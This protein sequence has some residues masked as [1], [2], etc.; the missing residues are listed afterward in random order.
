MI[1]SVIL[2]TTL[3]LAMYMEGT[4][5]KQSPSR[6][7]LETFKLYIY[8]EGLNRSFLRASSHIYKEG[9]IIK[10]ASVAASPKLSSCIYIYIYIYM[11]GTITKQVSVAASSKLSNYT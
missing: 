4:I 3:D 10:Q 7:F 6:S 5:F 1:L 8:K 9:M 2:V 11:E